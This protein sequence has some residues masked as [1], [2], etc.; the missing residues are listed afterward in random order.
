[1]VNNGTQYEAYEKI[2]RKA[3]VTDY[4]SLGFIALCVIG[5]IVFFL[6]LYRGDKKYAQEFPNFENSKESKRDKKVYIVSLIFLGLIFIGSTFATVNSIIRINHDITNQAYVLVD[7]TFTVVE[8]EWWGR[9]NDTTY[10]IEYETNG[11][12][13][14]IHPELQFWD[15]PAGEHENMAFVYAKESEIILDLKHLDP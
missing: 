8:T 6:W 3:L 11:V 2:L 12:K 4:I 15:L 1:M 14:E 5:I 7:Q 10:T 13:V 9:W